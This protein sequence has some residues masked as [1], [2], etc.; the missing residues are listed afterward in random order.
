MRQQT[1]ENLEVIIVG[2]RCDDNTDVVV[3]GFCDRRFKFF[4]L[5]TRGPYPRPGYNRWLVA[6]TNAVNIALQR[7]TGDLVT[8]LD[9]DDTYEPHRIETLVR[10]LQ[11]NEAD[12]VFHP[13]YWENDDH[14]WTVLGNGV[15]ELGQTGTGLVLYHNW[16]A[17]IPWDVDAFRL[18]EPGDWNRLRRF[19]ALGA[20]LHY[21][22]QILARHWKYP[23]REAFVAKPGETFLD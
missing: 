21:V 1:Y 16:F 5:D 9:E 17:K 10:E 3:A 11:R 14:S 7:A 8:H 19:R 22:D 6:G 20:N 18:G 15:F 23:V 2:D 13:F 12:L 4:N